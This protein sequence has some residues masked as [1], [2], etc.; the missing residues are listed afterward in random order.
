MKAFREARAA[1]LTMTVLGSFPTA[2]LAGV[3]FVRGDANGDGVVSFADLRAL[4]AHIFRGEE[5]PCRLAGDVDDNGS[6]SMGDVSVLWSWA[7]S[8]TQSIAAPFPEPGPDPTLSFVLDCGSY[9]SGSP[10]EDPQARI[11]VLDAIAGGGTEGT[12]LVRVAITNSVP[13]LGY[14]GELRVAEDLLASV[15][16]RG[17]S[18][19]PQIR[20]VLN[21]NGGRLR[22]AGTD[23][24]PGEAPPSDPG[25]IPPG[26]HVAAVEIPMCLAA[27]ATAGEYELALEAGELIHAGTYR[28][29]HPALGRGTLRLLA[30]LALPEDCG[31]PPGLNA[32]FELVGATAPPGGFGNVT[33]KMRADADIQAFAYSVDFDE[34]VLEALGTDVVWQR[35]DG[36]E[37]EFARHERNN[38]NATPGSGGVDEGFFIGYAVFDTRE[39]IAMPANVDHEAVRFRLRVR[40]ET[41]ATTTE[42]GFVDG[43]RGSGQPVVNLVTANGNTEYTRDIASSFIFISGL[44]HVIPDIVTFLRGDAN[45]DETVDI[46]DAQRTLNHLFLGSGQ[47]ACFDAADAN[48]DGSL[49]IADAIFTLHHLFSGG[50]A[51]PPPFPEAGPDPTGDAFGCLHAGS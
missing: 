30:D 15:P 47:P 37:F 29:I 38:D 51:I 14:H 21:L 1:V 11:E 5:I 28:A 8:Y 16:E 32:S 50:R 24:G 13:I 49:N 44:I 27:G 34:E 26:Q 17:N 46:A 40:P 43:G 22:F 20:C 45:G 36:L 48:D 18:L 2:D 4:L 12:A 25:V 23:S 6:L 41:T 35:P 7:L 39:P 3:D 9:G 33:L 31:P 10:L 19:I 42:L